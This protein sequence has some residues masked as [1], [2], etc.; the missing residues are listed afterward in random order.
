MIAFLLFSPM[1]LICSVLFLN[2]LLFRCQTFRLSKHLFFL[3]YF[4]RFPQ[5]YPSTYVLFFISAIIYTFVNFQR[6]F[7]D[8]SMFL[9]GCFAFVS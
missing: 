4:L 3:F 9:L 8:L 5:I 7:Y 1:T 6:L 2:F